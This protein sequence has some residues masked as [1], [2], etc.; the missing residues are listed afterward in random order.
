MNSNFEWQ[1]QLANERVQA[2]LREADEHVRS[3]NWRR[4]S[5]V[6]AIMTQLLLGAAG[7]I[8]IVLLIAGCTPVTPA[9]P[10]EGASAA[11]PLAGVFPM[12][13]SL[14]DLMDYYT[15]Q[16]EAA[17][18]EIGAPVQNRPAHPWS[19]TDWNR[20]HD[21]LVHA[22]DRPAPSQSPW[23]MADRVRFQDRLQ[24]GPEPKGGP[25][26]KDLENLERWGLEHRY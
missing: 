2:A 24:I 8:L 16:R 18:G 3:Q 6:R 12:P 5:L 17:E 25:D 19:V 13:Y 20:F 7:L 14:D 15:S 4:R 1:K 21:R 10:G 9:L 22:D 26:M 11:S 23:S